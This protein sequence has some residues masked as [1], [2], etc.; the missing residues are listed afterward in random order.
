MT[1]FKASGF[2]IIE[3]MLAVTALSVLLLA[4]AMLSLQVGAIYQR[5]MTLRSMNQSARELSDVMRRDFLQAKSS[6]IFK[7]PSG[8]NAYVTVSSGGVVYGGRIC[9]GNESYV[10]NTA[11]GLANPSSPKLAK[12]GGNKPINL[13]RMR[14]IGGQFCR[15]TS[16]SGDYLMNIP[17]D[18]GV[19][20]LLRPRNND[21][22]LAL[23]DMK[24]IRIAAA[25]SDVDESLHRIEF[26]LGTSEGSD[27]Y[28]N[29]TVPTSK[30]CRPPADNQSNAEYCA[31]NFFQ[32]VVRSNG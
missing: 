1:R 4:I 5:G 32:I 30:T 13:I 18:P 16:P 25:S 29:S 24:A 20:H 31:I 6:D 10:W 28:D 11:R 3:L 23:H 12:Q 26:T 21:T 7:Q 17:S 14:D 8:Q 15:P 22:V 9:L 27:F 19:T 2:T